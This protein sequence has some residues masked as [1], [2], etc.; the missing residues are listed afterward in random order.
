VNVW[1]SSQI[2]KIFE[3]IIRDAMVHHQGDM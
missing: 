2:C 3:T 1:F